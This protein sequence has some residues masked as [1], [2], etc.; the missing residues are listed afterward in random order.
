MDLH[1]RFAVTAATMLLALGAA[2]MPGA[3]ASAAVNAKYNIW[4]WNIAGA[5]MHGGSTT[6][7]LIDAAAN[8]IMNRA[9]D[10]VAFNEICQGQFNA[11]IGRLRE[12]NYPA[13]ESNFA[14]FTASLDAAE[15]CAPGAG[16]TQPFGNAIFS[17][18]PLNGAQRWTLPSDTRPEQRNLTCVAPT[19]QPKMHF[20]TTHITTNNDTAPNSKQYNE[21][22]LDFVLDRMEAFDSA[23]DTAVIAGDFNGQPHY[24]RLDNWYSPTLNVANNGG[25]TGAYRELDDNDSGNCLGYGEWT[26]TGTP[27]ATPPC[28]GLAKIDLIFAR[29]SRLVG[30]YSSDSLSISTACSGIPATSA[31]PAGSCSDHRIVIGTATVSIG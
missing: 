5:T 12:L 19:A 7:G 28:G 17:R 24:D 18:F 16:N 21:N 23:G 31:Y 13:D 25:N 6:D 8:S 29:Q 14:R 4:T 20:C 15:G 2:I 11:L 9:A 26:A 3:P 30:S 10:F 22:Q 1:K 27:G